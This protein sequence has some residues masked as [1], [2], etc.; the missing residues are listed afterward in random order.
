[1]EFISNILWKISSFQSFS[2][3]SLLKITFRFL[4]FL[5]NLCQLKLE[6]SFMK[7]FFSFGVE[8]V[9]NLKFGIFCH[10]SKI[11]EHMWNFLKD[12]SL[13]NIFHAKQLLNVKMLLQIK[14]MEKRNLVENGMD[15]I[16]LKGFK[17]K[18]SKVLL[19]FSRNWNY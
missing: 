8:K 11:I 1:M 10:K 5:G 3:L 18:V 15:S 4:F 19:T 9:V 14:M 7:V 17:L 2:D 12:L 13:K 16:F 6:K